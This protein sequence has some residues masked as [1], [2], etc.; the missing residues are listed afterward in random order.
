MQ[1]TVETVVAGIAGVGA[2]FL[3]LQKV[4]LIYFGVGRPA[5]RRECAKKCSAHEEMVAK[6]VRRAEEARQIKEDITEIKSSIHDLTERIDDVAK[7]LHEAI[8]W[9]RGKHNGH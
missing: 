1:I 2:V 6:A 5:E 3:A 8:G 7:N 4:G 9:M